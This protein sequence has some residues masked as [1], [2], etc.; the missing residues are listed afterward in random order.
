MNKKSLRLTLAI[1]ALIL[2]VPAITMIFTDQVNW[3]VFDFII[4][5]ILLYGASFAIYLSA[6]LKTK[7]LR[8]GLTAAIFL[9]LI[10]VWAELAVG[11][12]GTPFAGN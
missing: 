1:P 12:S 3:S 6:T 5:A 2:L 8:I 7:W 9:V 11:I 4:A 10:I